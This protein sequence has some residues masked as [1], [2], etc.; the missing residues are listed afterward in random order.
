LLYRYF[1]P[2]FILG[3]FENWAPVVTVTDEFTRLMSR[4][5]HFPKTFAV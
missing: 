5:V 3:S 1:F 4:R 2:Q